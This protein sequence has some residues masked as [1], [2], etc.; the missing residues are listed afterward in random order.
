MEEAPEECR[1]PPGVGVFTIPQLD[2]IF[3]TSNQHWLNMIESGE[4]FAWDLRMPG[5]TKSMMRIPRSALVKFL[6][7]RQ[8]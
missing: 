5:T 6:E 2:E 3:Q 7:K 4:L 8:Q 1:L